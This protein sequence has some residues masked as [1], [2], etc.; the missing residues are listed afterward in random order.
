MSSDTPRIECPIFAL[1]S[2]DEHAFSGRGRNSHKNQ[3]GKPSMRGILTGATRYYESNSTKRFMKAGRKNSKQPFLVV[4]CFTLSF[5]AFAAGT[6]R[7]PTH[8]RSGET[9]IFSCPFKNQKTVSLCASSDLSRDSGTLQYRFGRTG[10]PFE[11]SYPRQT[12]HPSRFFWFNS[13]HGGQWAQYALGFS[14]NQFR[15]ELLVQTNSA[16]PDDGASLS[17]LRDHHRIA[18]ME[19]QFENSVNNMWMLE[20]L[21]IQQKP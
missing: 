21:G 5:S 2:H 17:V 12:G 3:I 13:S 4:A 1:I 10:K 16:I 18:D 9:V 6:P 14:M 15:Y 11:L 20:P 19:C 7:A 8:C